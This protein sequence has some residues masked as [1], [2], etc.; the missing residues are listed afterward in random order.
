MD[1]LRLPGMLVR[2]RPVGPWRIGPDSGARDRVDHIL[3]SDALYS[4]VCSA[5]SQLGLLSDWL[6]ATA[7]ADS[8]P[9]VRFTS[10]FPWQEDELFVVP[11]RNLWPPPPSAKVRWKGAR[12]IPLSLVSL[13][14]SEKQVDEERWAVDPVSD[15]LLPA[16]R[17][18]AGGPF[19]IS[20]RSSAAVDRLSPGLNDVHATAC[21][22]FADRAGMWCAVAFSNDEARQRWSGPVKSALRLLA[23][24]GI[25]GERS[26]GWGR[27]LSPSIT[28]GNI[29]ALLLP[30]LKQSTTEVDLSPSAT[31]EPAPQAEPAIELSPPESSR[32]HEGAVPDSASAPER[33][34]EATPTAE[35]T[36]PEPAAAVESDGPRAASQVE[37]EIERNPPALSRDREEAVPDSASAP[38]PEIEATPATE[39][40]QPE[41]AAAGEPS[42]GPVPRTEPEIEPTPDADATEPEP[43]AAVE[44]ATEPEPQAEP[45]IEPTPESGEAQLRGPR[46]ETPLLIGGTEDVTPEKEPEPAQPSEAPAPVARPQPPELPAP[47]ATAWW[48]LSL[49]S[50]SSADAI[51]WSRGNYTTLSRTGRIESSARWGEMK[52]SLRMVGEGSVLLAPSQPCGYAPD[53]APDGFPHPVFR[54]GFAFAIPIPW[55]ISQ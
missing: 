30:K 6:A 16:Q 18:F 5:M 22:E 52:K 20:V 29:P 4:A 27:S 48:L 32:D 51:D 54:S 9:A 46:L 49:Y 12:F 41:F 55:R 34:I 7:Q 3:H 35:V 44:S 21:L 33:E 28:E 31:P 19:R 47:P 2:F 11:P 1:E 14:L 43:A 53:V 24:S 50:P 37:P 26:R 25:G 39:A 13:L 36:E 23:D 45:E 40:S 38:E 8:E 15:C 17:R 42:P 10:C